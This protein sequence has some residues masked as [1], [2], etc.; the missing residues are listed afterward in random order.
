M[1]DRAAILVTDRIGEKQSLTPEG[2]L[3]CEDVKIA[4]VGD[5]DYLPNEVPEVK[6]DRGIVRLT[7]DAETLFDP[8]TLASFAGKP[9]TNDHPPSFVGPGTFKQYSVGSVLE[10][11][12]GEGVNDGY[13]VADLLIMDQK[14]IKDVRAGKRQVSCGYDCDRVEI[15][16]GLGRQTKIV[17]NHVA[18]VVRGRAGPSCA[19]TDEDTM[20]QKT[21]IQRIRAA[22]TTQ[23]RDALEEGLDELRDEDAPEEDKKD[24]K[25]EDALPAALLSAISKAVTDGM[26]PLADSLAEIKKTLDEDSDEED[27]ETEDEDEEDKGETMDAATLADAYREALARAEIVAPGIKAPTFDAAA[28]VSAVT[29]LQRSAL[30][31]AFANPKH[32][33]FVTAILGPKPNFEKLT[34]DAAGIAL[35]GVSEAIKATNNAPKPQVELPNRPGAMTPARLQELNAAARK[36]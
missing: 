20:P 28:G 16:P 8:I 31:A 4:R 32:T 10:P 7:R 33:S 13:L 25:T 9:V 5:M 11:R 26:K 35:R 14:A 1:Q 36:K 29:A 18:L 23:D 30:A 2:F 22:F 27:T 17:G 34:A 6:P 12:R 15:R 19:I 24:Q 3:L 21:L